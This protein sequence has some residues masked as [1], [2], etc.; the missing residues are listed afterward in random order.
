MLALDKQTCFYEYVSAGNM[1]TFMYRVLLRSVA[2]A[3]K[4]SNLEVLKKKKVWLE[5]LA[6]VSYYK[7]GPWYT[8]YILILWRCENSPE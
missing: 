7:K 3:T 2:N 4:T 8:V 1:H 6:A 5:N